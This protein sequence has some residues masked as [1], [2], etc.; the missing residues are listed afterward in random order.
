M[1]YTF[2]IILGVLLIILGIYADRIDTPKD[3]LE[4][5]NSYGEIEELVILEKRVAHIEKILFEDISDDIP[6]EAEENKAKSGFEKYILLR[7]YESEDYSME[8]I[9]KLLNMNKGEV[10]LLKKLYKNYLS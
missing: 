1:M 8:E 10:L 5:Q 9:C 2:L 3:T 6:L 4:S 7:K